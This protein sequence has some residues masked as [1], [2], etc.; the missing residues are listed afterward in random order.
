MSYDSSLDNQ[1]NTTKKFAKM[2]FGPYIVKQVNDNAT[3][4]LRELDGTELKLPIAGK[5]IRLF[6]RT[7][8]YHLHEESMVNANED[9][10]DVYDEEPSE[11]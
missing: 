7:N 6:R 1:H 3:Y 2:W 10:E 8:D 11:D 5:M 4:F 9:E